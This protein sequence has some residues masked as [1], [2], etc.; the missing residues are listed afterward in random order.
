MLKAEISIGVPGHPQHD[1]LGSVVVGLLHG[2]AKFPKCEPCMVEFE[3]RDLA[4][5][6]CT[7]LN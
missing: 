2:K 3:I 4:M 6:F 7:I 1:L 5:T